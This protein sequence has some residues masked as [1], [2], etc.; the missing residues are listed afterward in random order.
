M[1]T[2]A[3]SLFREPQF[4]ERNDHAIPTQRISAGL[5]LLAVLIGAGLFSVRNPM[6]VYT[7][8][9]PLPTATIPADDE[10]DVPADDMTAP[11]GAL[12][13]ASREKECVTFDYLG[14]ETGADGTTTIQFQVTNRCN[15]EL[16]WIEIVT[17]QWEQME[18]GENSVYSGDLGDYTVTWI[19]DAP[20]YPERR[21]YRFKTDFDTFSGGAS[22]IVSVQVENF[23]PFR[24]MRIRAR[25]GDTIDRAGVRPGNFACGVTPG[26]TPTPPPAQDICLSKQDRGVTVDFYGYVPYPDGTTGLTFGVTN[27]NQRQLDAVGI[28]AGGWNRVAPADGTVYRGVLGSYNVRWVTQSDTPNQDAVRFKA[29]GSW[30]QGGASDHFTVRVNNFDPTKR[31]TVWAQRNGRIELKGTLA[32]HDCERALPPTPTAT[33]T[34]PNSPLVTP[35]S[36]PMPTPTPGPVEPLD[37]QTDADGDGEPDALIAA[38]NKLATLHAAYQDNPNSDTEAALDQAYAEFFQSL[39]YSERTLEI[40][41]E[42]GQLYEQILQSNDDAEI[43][44]LQAEFDQLERQLYDDSNFAI[45]DRVLSERLDEAMRSKVGATPEAASEGQGAAEPQP[46][47]SVSPAA[48]DTAD[49]AFRVHLP[50]IGNIRLFEPDP[51]VNVDTPADFSTLE[52]GHLMFLRTN[53]KRRNFQYAKKFTHI[54]IYDGLQSDGVSIKVYESNPI[55]PN[56]DDSDGGPALWPYDPWE[57]VEGWCVALGYYDTSQLSLPTVQDAIDWAKG[58]LGVNGEIPYVQN[59]LDFLDKESNETSYCS[60]LIWQ[61]YDHLGINVDSND[62]AYHIWFISRWGSVF[63]IGGTVSGEVAARFFVAP[64]EIFRHDSMIIYSEG[65]N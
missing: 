12:V 22:D 34:S 59:P 56:G 53:S 52:R 35:T 62:L 65:Q 37:L 55:G 27:G 42:M 58:E 45:V 50:V 3:T 31:I 38:L 2:Q 24:R 23:N 64:D 51:C 48:I 33:P 21:G 40:Q 25:V 14:Y 19:D 20:D 63:G 6:G 39:A 13:C 46:Q 18:P 61:I 41:Q 8:Q 29:W 43:A 44:A 30:F 7:Q 1:N 17:R 11:E 57:N 60:K 36:T 9:S 32:N 10:P 47:S 4:D 54:G 16:R 49:L 28:K 26:P 5:F 15:Q